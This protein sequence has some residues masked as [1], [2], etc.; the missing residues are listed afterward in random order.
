MKKKV[1]FVKSAG[2][3]IFEEAYFVLKSDKKKENRQNNLTR[4]IV[5]EANRII[6]E[7]IGNDRKR[8]HTI[9]FI[10]ALSFLFGALTSMSVALVLIL[11]LM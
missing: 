5:C 8:K 1:I 4:D 9:F 11:C 6:D 7:K 10:G 2:S 3:D